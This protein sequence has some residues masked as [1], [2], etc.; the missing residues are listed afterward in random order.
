MSFRKSKISM[1]EKLFKINLLLLPNYKNHF[2]AKKNTKEMDPKW[3][4]KFANS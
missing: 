2:K 3:T 4:F 1:E